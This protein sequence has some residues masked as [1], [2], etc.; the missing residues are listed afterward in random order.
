MLTSCSTVKASLTFILS[1]P[2]AWTTFGLRSSPSAPEQTQK[3]IVKNTSSKAMWQE[4][5]QS[6]T[7][8][9]VDKQLGDALWVVVLLVL[10]NLTGDHFLLHL[11]RAKQKVMWL[12]KHPM[13][14]GTSGRFSPGASTQDW[15]SCSN[16]TPC[17]AYTACAGVLM[18]EDTE[19]SLCY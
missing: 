10:K 7:E 16:S 15:S 5:C 6:L 2:R 14:T 13:L 17:S 11:F 8:P 19:C 4:T 12:K 9:G 1:L 18:P 3:V